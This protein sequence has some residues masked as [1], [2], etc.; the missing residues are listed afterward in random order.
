[1]KTISIWLLI[2]C[3]LPRIF[4]PAEGIIFEKLFSKSAICYCN[5]NSN[6][7]IHANKEDGFFKKKTALSEISISEK[8][9]LPNCHSNIKKIA[10]ECDCK[11]EKSDRVLTQI[12]VFSYFLISSRFFLLPIIEFSYLINNRDWDR[13]SR[14]YSKKLKRPPKLLSS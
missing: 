1:M 3:L 9:N 8:N 4:V 11:K 12:R 7:E 6:Q 2:C 10:H 5:H 14:A 13:L